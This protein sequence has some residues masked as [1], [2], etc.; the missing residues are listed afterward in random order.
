MMRFFLIIIVLALFSCIKNEEKTNQETQKTSNERKKKAKALNILFDALLRVNIDGRISIN[1]SVCST[2]IKIPE[3]YFSSKD[4]VVL[5]SYM[6][7]IH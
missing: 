7:H 6:I 4:S 1:D 2:F 5:V 3:N